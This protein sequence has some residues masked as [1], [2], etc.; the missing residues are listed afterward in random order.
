MLLILALVGC[1]GRPSTAAELCAD[2]P[3]Y[4]GCDRDFADSCSTALEAA[5]AD[6]PECEPMFDALAQCIGRL[7][8]SC[9]PTDQLAAVGDGE[10]DGPDNFTSFGARFD[11]IVNDT[12]CDL[13]KRGVDACLTC[14]DAAGA[15]DPEHK[16]IGEPCGA[17]TECASGL[18]CEDGQCTRGCESSDDCDAR[19]KECRMK[20]QFGN[21]CAEIDGEDRCT[22]SCT[23]GSFDCEFLFGE[24][25]SCV[26]EACVPG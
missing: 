13:Y 26:D 14:P 5:L 18:D 20:Y 22:R 12:S 1:G 25:Y 11:W 10:F 3:R 7:E 17:A 21:T 4:E 16:G 8:L 24:G 23:N 9:V 15:T 19:S 6:S 2:L